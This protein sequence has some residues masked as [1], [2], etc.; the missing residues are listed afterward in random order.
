MNT[1]HWA[2][3]HLIGYL[4]TWPAVKHFIKQNNY[5]PID[6]LQKDIE[7][8]WGNEQTKEVHF[9]LLLRIGRITK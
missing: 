6:K 7:Q 3:E 5:N 4:N 1:Q 2:L 9:P 8:L